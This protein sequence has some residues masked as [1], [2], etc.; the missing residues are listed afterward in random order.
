MKKKNETTLEEK[1]EEEESIRQEIGSLVSAL[2]SPVSFIGDWKVVKIYEAR[3]KGEE[4]PYDYE[5]LSARRQEARDR[6]NELQAQ[7]AELQ[8]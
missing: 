1:R 7:L 8:K 3:L 6:I 5:E 4:D 2:D